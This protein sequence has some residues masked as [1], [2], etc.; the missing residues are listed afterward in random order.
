M[1]TVGA[2]REE[3]STG[4][5]KRRLSTTMLKELLRRAASKATAMP[6]WAYRGAQKKRNSCHIFSVETTQQHN[7]ASSLCAQHRGD[8]TRHGG[9]T[10]ARTEVKT[11][12][13]FKH[14]E[15][16]VGGSHS[17][18]T[19]FQSS[20]KS[21]TWSHRLCCSFQWRQLPLVCGNLRRPWCE[22]WLA[23]RLAERM[24]GSKAVFGPFWAQQENC[25]W[26]LLTPHGC[27]K[28]ANPAAGRK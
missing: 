17:R 26:L 3:S 10:E 24:Q 19:T 28:A 4:R 20:Q 15:H 12:L 14:H 7:G 5:S 27:F 23:L 25:D 2:L 16:K 8:W 22:V 13:C 21:R 11:G 6:Y 18:M 1:D 9:L